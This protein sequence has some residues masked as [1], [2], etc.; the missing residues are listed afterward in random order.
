[1]LG[2]VNKVAKMSQKSQFSQHNH[3]RDS[4]CNTEITKKLYEGGII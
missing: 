4:S 2:L 1:M 3:K